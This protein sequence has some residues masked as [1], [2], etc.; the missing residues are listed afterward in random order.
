VAI[1]NA[2]GSGGLA[3]KEANLLKSYGYN[4][5]T[6]DNAPNAT[7][8]PSTSLVDLTH[9]TDKYTLRYLEG[10]LGV[11]A[12][13]QVPGGFGIAPPQGTDFVIILGEDAA[14]SAVT[15]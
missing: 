3:T 10:R 2:T 13:G 14:S 8:P 4:V 6:I 5:T 1:Y 7:D 11:T 15:Q 12:A 9:G